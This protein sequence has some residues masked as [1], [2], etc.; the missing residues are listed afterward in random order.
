MIFA[1]AL[2]FGFLPKG[3]ELLGWHAMVESLLAVQQSF[4]G[5]VFYGVVVFI[6]EFLP[7]AGIKPKEIAEYFSLMS[8][9]IQG[10][11]PGKPTEDHMKEKLM[12]CKF[13]GGLALGGLAVT[14][15]LF[16]ILCQSFLGTTLGTT[17][18]LIIVG[19][20][21]QTTKQMN[22]L[23]DSPRLNTQLSAEQRMIRKLDEL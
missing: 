22:A 17:S 10:I 1:G 16:D 9:G 14:A 2:Y 19:A 8:V 7:V 3:L 20:V 4:F 23:L 6:M 11:V 5:L 15:A 21:M 12:K 13:W 18:L